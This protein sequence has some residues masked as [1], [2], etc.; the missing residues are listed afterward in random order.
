MVLGGGALIGV[1][2]GFSPA[3]A[4]TD[5]DTAT[6][7]AAIPKRRNA[8]STDVKVPS[9]HPQINNLKQ[10]INDAKG[11]RVMIDETAPS[12]RKLKTKND[13][14][15]MAYLALKKITAFG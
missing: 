8:V 12:I 9:A 15:N 5:D 2:T 13:F 11:L 3:S 6:T 4:A 1:A 14:L 10:G 7:Q